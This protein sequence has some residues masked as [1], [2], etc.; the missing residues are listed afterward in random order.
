MSTP[1][2][3]STLGP[4]QRPC[5]ACGKAMHRQSKM[6]R[7]CYHQQH[8]RPQSYVERACNKCALSFT[9]HRSQVERGQGIYCSRSCARSGSPTKRKSAPRV[10]CGVCGKAFYKHQSEIRKTRR[11][12][13][14]CSS[15]CWYEYNQRENHYMWAGGQNERM[16]PQSRVWRKAVLERDG[17]F[18]RIC[19]AT[20]KLEAHHI[21]PFGTHPERRWE[22][23]NGLTL[24][25]ECHAR[26]RYRELENAEMFQFIASI[27]VQVCHVEPEQEP[28]TGASSK[29]L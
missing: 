9:V 21:L 2:S 18:C 17:G 29:L 5:P 24:C 1:N 26:V 20:D 27:P 25:K 3:Q 8:T 6:C 23:S 16:N 4:N 22:V 14:F 28:D 19:H 15:G 11:G 12:M 7:D 10:E 13:H